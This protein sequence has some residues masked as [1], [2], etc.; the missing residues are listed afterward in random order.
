MIDAPVVATLLAAKFGTMRTI[1]SLGERR[2]R[3]EVPGSPWAVE[4]IMMLRDVVDHCDRERLCLDPKIGIEQLSAF[5]QRKLG[6]EPVEVFY[7]FFFSGDA[8]LWDGELVRGDSGRVNVSVANIVRRAVDLSAT[9]IVL[10]HN[11]PSG[12]ATPSSA[13]VS[14]TR[15]IHRAL[16]AIGA[17]VFDHLLVAGNEVVSLRARQLFVD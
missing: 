4:R 9:V 12:D 14:T 10:A 15:A 16:S 13:D 8:L 3:R 17:R 11:H 2:L 6:T 7:A 5:V 1:L